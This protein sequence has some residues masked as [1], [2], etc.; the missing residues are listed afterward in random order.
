MPVGVFIFSGRS[1]LFVCFLIEKGEK[2]RDEE[3]VLKVC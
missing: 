2:V 1:C 3:N